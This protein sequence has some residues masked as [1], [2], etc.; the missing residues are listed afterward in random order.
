MAADPPFSRLDLVS[1]RNVLIYM[2][3]ALQKRVLPLLHYALNPDGFLFL[4]SS[5]NIG[6]FA[7]LFDVVDAKHRIFAK[8]PAAAGAAAGLQPARRRPRAGPGRP[9]G[10]TA[11]PL[12]N[13]LDVQKE[14]DRI[15]L[16]RY[17]PVGVVVDEAMTVLQFRGRTAAYLEPAPGMAS[18]D[19]FRMLREG[20]LAE[21][22]AAVT[23]AK[24]ENAVVARDGLR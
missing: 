2:D 1:C 7:D 10:T 6:A 23:Q 19:L 20:L 8:K 15:L 3:A 18:L 16:A 24:A 13:A 17:A 11:P 12:W 14:A 9:A 4:G 5:E 22:R 21:V